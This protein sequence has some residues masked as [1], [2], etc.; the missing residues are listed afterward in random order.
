MTS[1]TTNNDATQVPL[2]PP[3]RRFQT[4]RRLMSVGIIIAVLA[5]GAAGGAGA[6]RYVQKPHQQSVLLLQ[7]APIGQMTDSTAVAV[8]GWW[9]RCSATK[10][11]P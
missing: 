2:P 6:Y 5:V 3:P 1:E 11:A 7:P 4:S 8:K 10:C 9:P